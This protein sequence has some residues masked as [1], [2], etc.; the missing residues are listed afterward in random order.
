MYIKSTVKNYCGQKKI[1]L[2]NNFHIITQVIQNSWRKIREEIKNVILLLKR[3]NSC[4]RN[5]G[6]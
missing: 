4:K 1:S 6:H 3:Q 2:F 5:N